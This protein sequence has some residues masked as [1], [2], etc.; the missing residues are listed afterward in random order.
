MLPKKVFDF[1]DS[2]RSYIVYSSPD[3][4]LRFPNDEVQVGRAA[5]SQLRKGRDTVDSSYGDRSAAPAGWHAGSLLQRQTWERDSRRTSEWMGVSS[6]ATQVHPAKGLKQGGM[7]LHGCPTALGS[8]H[9]G[10]K[11][12]YLPRCSP[13]ACAAVHS[14]FGTLS[15]NLRSSIAYIQ[16]T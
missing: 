11:Y 3:V 2:I 9:D 6:S 13:V 15:S 12:E 16:T 14:R 5:A 1:Q 8:C 7:Y 4:L 10:V